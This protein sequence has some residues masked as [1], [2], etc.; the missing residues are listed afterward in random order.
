MGRSLECV[1]AGVGKAVCEELLEDEVKLALRWCARRHD[2]DL[3]GNCSPYVDHPIATRH[4]TSRA[5]QFS[6]FYEAQDLT[7]QDLTTCRI[8]FWNYSILQY[9]SHVGEIE[10][11]ACSAGGVVT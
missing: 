5:G 7:T 2:G 9:P 8:G 6:E 4:M 10:R 3:L 1:G 11:E